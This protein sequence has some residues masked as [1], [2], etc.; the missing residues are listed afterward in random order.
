MIPY[1][2]QEI[3]QDDIDAV[4][5]ALKSDYLTQGPQVPLFEKELAEYCNASH[6][7]A[8]NSAT[9]ALHIACLAI[10]IGHGDLVWTSPI[11]F[12]ASA[13]CVRYCGADV[14]FV[15]INPITYNLSIDAL[16][17]KLKKAQSQNRIPKAIIAVH[18]CGQSCNMAAIHNLSKEYGFRIIEDASHGVGGR[19]KSQPIGSCQYSDITVFSFHPVKIITTAEGGM[20]LTNKPHLA[21]KMQLLRSHGITRDESRMTEPSHGSWYYQQLVLGFNFRMTDIQAALGRSQLKRLDHF[22]ASRNQLSNQYDQLLRDLPVIVPQQEPECLSARH[23]YVIRMK[24][25]ENQKTR[26]QVFDELQG[27]GIGVNVHYIPVHTQPYYRNLGFNT[28]D[29]PEA[30]RYYNESISIPLY[31]HM[32]HEQQNMVSIALH[33]VFKK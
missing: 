22:V 32:N 33:K 6:A 3:T 23:L 21:S 16:A 13:N 12:V 18:L 14:D 15:D 30:E 31:H 24:T 28:G 17:A 20:A 7:V 29:F 19:Y 26:R 10:G 2:R 9:S 4:I 11:T 27:E 25:S 1:G 8:V 5:D